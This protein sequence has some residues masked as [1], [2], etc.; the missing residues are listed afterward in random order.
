MMKR[1]IKFRAWD[2]KYKR[3]YYGGDIRIALAC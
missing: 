3:M 2:K 1:D